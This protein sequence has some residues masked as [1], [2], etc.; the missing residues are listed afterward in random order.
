MQA[1][2][3]RLGLRLMPAD[4][5]EYKRWLPEGTNG[6]IEFKATVCMFD[7][8]RNQWVS[9]SD[10][11]ET[12]KERL[13]RTITFNM[14]SSTEKG[15]CMNF[16][17]DG[18]SDPDLFFACPCALCDGDRG[19]KTNV[20][21]VL[22]NDSTPAKDCP[23]NI[24]N[25]QQPDN[26]KHAHHYLQAK[27][28]DK[29]PGA[30]VWIRSE[31]YGAYGVL[32]AKA[33]D[34][35]AIPPVDIRPVPTR[36][37]KL[38][39]FKL[40]DTCAFCSHR[41]VDKNS[42]VAHEKTD[43]Q[44]VNAIFG[45]IGIKVEMGEALPVGDDLLMP[46]LSGEE[47]N[48]LLV[49][50]MKSI[51]KMKFQVKDF[52]EDVKK[53]AKNGGE[54]LAFWEFLKS[55][56]LVQKSNDWAPARGTVSVDVYYV[57]KFLKSGVFG[58]TL[59][60]GGE[61][62][63]V[64]YTGNATRPIIVISTGERRAE[65]LAH[66][67][68][69]VLLNDDG[70]DSD[71]G[72]LMA[73]SAG[74]MAAGISSKQ[75]SSMI[76]S[77]S[78]QVAQPEQ[79]SA[80]KP[81]AYPLR[82]PFDDNENDIA[83]AAAQDKFEGIPVLPTDDEE[84]VDGNDHYGDGLTSF[85][86]YRG[87]IVLGP[88]SGRM[89]DRKSKVHVRTS[90]ERKDIFLRLEMEEVTKERA[91]ETN[92]SLLFT[93]RALDLLKNEGIDVHIL[94]APHFYNGDAPITDRYQPMGG[95]H[96]INFNATT[97]TLGAQHGIRIIGAETGQSI[98]V[99][100]SLKNHRGFSVQYVPGFKNWDEC[101]KKRGCPETTNR[102][103]IILSEMKKSEDFLK[104]NKA[105]YYGGA[106]P[107]D[108]KLVADDYAAVLAHEVFHA[109]GVGHHSS[110]KLTDTMNDKKHAFIVIETDKESEMN[111]PTLIDLS[112]FA[113]R[114]NTATVGWRKLSEKVDES[115]GERVVVRQMLLDEKEAS[116]RKNAGE[117]I[118]REQKVDVF[119]EAPGKWTSG[120]S[121]CIMRY[122]APEAVVV[123]KADVPDFTDAHD[124]QGRK[125]AFI[126]SPDTPTDEDPK[127]GWIIISRRCHAPRTHLCTSKDATG[128]NVIKSGEKAWSNFAT[129]GN[130]KSQIH[131][132]DWD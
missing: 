77:A 1:A 82:I 50:Y 23:T 15:I 47:Y 40:G 70:H 72:N 108:E 56:D 106:P 41:A 55:G 120:D 107:D 61:N 42:K 101:P 117:K 22:D 52:G 38:N 68:G 75:K 66:E 24:L 93:D 34:C 85:E 21:L 109:I 27:T 90:V 71:K 54:R 51:G 124:E 7:T 130:C 132:R 128:I 83:D 28:R 62:R 113:P 96:R 17:K 58:L 100:P 84:Y 67:L 92:P 97:H 49:Q 31:D 80:E 104:E 114:A 16:P 44:V 20:G 13:K 79:H 91:L 115:K 35:E 87:F 32:Q 116:D 11:P 53:K 37:V 12:S 64:G 105:R 127:Y 18:N 57:P 131:I 98:Y 45:S 86:E 123:K 46:N 112:S 8:I 94:P 30:S 111:A 76:R 36:K 65:T 99:D 110:I 78:V 14:K 89:E 48:D 5:G 119:C 118:I 121:D 6:R 33:D 74:R 29:V 81:Q 3:V 73:D 69:H 19:A 125:F 88:E 25:L 95:A 122:V 43:L 103:V 129:I 9:V 2:K 60:P 39:V 59:R 102:C 126:A 10:L 26:P 63:L 4:D